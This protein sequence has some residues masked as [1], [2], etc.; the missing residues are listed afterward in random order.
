MNSIFQDGPASLDIKRNIFYITRSSKTFGK[1][2]LIQLDLYYIPFEKSTG[3]IAIPLTIN[4]QNYSSMHP[5]VSPD[6]NRLYFSSDR[7]GG[8]GGMDLY[9]VEILKD[10]QLG[11]P[12]NLG[13]DIN[14]S[15]DEVFPLSF[16][17]NILFYSYN[18]NNNQG[19]EELNIKIVKHLI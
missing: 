5:S 2:N 9:F 16:S 18:N 15:L 19:T 11:K 6:G 17:K 4:G 7:P 1:D 12:V 14:S 8:F 3:K 13:P 10:N